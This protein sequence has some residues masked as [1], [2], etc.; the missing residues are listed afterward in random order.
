MVVPDHELTKHPLET[1]LYFRLYSDLLRS[2]QLG[3]CVDTG[4]VR[5]QTGKMDSELG[6][7]FYAFV[8]IGCFRFDDD[9]IFRIDRALRHCQLL[10]QKIQKVIIHP[11]V[12]GEK[13]FS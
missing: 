8:L 7:V 11:E 5:I 3:D 6:G 13:S 2:V 1:I 9:H 10:F 4:M 12:M